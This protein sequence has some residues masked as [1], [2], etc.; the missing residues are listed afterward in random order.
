MGTSVPLDEL[1]YGELTLLE[2]RHGFKAQEVRIESN[3]ASGDGSKP[4]T[5]V[6]VGPVL[7]STNSTW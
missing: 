4:E 2:M 5:V 7:R 3:L 6:F 1:I